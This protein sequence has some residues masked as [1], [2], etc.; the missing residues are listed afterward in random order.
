MENSYKK[1]FMVTEDLYASQRQR[2]G[3]YILDLIVQYVLAAA[4]GV[5][6]VL[7]A[8][9]TDS[10]GLAYWVQ[11]MNRVEEYLLGIVI[12]LFYYT[13]T[14]TFLSRTVGKFITKTIVVMEDGSKPDA[15]SIFKRSLCRL[16]PFEHFSFLGANSRGWHDSIPDTYVVQKEAFEAKR[17]QFYE[18]DQIGLS[19]ETE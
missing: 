19:T 18:F 7:I 9:L 10:Y 13:T 1:P 2:L 16:I 6:V 15:M 3:N 11:D 5:A 17:K 4:F 14:E 12:M 8:E